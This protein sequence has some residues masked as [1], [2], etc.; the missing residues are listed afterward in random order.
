MVKSSFIIKVCDHQEL[1]Q[2]QKK[3]KKNRSI[4]VNKLDMEKVFD[5][6]LIGIVDDVFIV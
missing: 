1:A 3:E 4:F 2:S 5:L 6:D